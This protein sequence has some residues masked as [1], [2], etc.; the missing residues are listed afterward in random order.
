MSPTLYMWC[1][2]HD[3]YSDDAKD[4]LRK[5]SWRMAREAAESPVAQL[6]ERYVKRPK[7]KPRPKPRPYP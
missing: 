1:L 4:C 5:S 2:A 3:L 6:A 7:P